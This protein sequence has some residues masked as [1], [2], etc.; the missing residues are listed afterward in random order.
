M[1]SIRWIEKLSKLFQNS[2]IQILSEL[3]FEFLCI[4]V[5]LCQFIFQKNVVLVVFFLYLKMWLAF[6]TAEYMYPLLDTKI[7][8][9]DEKNTFYVLANGRYVCS[10]TSF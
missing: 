1:V 3:Y 10:R 9:K 2:K 7:Q 4:S 5:L 6:C 8:L